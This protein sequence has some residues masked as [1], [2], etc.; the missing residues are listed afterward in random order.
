MKCNFTEKTYQ[1]SKDIENLTL[2]EVSLDKDEYQF[3][4]KEIK[5]IDC[6]FG[7]TNIKLTRPSV[8]TIQVDLKNL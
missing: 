7:Q 8:V 4:C 3:N 6:K 2:M 1:I 5:I